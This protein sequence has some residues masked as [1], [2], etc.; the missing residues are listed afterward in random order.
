[1]LTLPTTI[2]KTDITPCHLQEGMTNSAAFTIGG[3]TYSKN[4]LVFK[5]FAGADDGTKTQSYKGVY[6]FDSGSAKE[7]FDFNTLPG[8]E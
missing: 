2:H 5:G 1:M 6:R 8:I 7:S 4:Q 3:K